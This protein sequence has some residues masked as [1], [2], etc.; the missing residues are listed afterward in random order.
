MA[1]G[2]VMRS[3]AEF[4]ATQ[5]PQSAPLGLLGGALL[6][7][8]WQAQWSKAQSA[9]IRSEREA[10]RPNARDHLPACQLATNFPAKKYF[11]LPPKKWQG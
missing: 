6:R 10:I 3:V 5:P 1:E 11:D 7:F 4:T 9:G 2:A 8:G